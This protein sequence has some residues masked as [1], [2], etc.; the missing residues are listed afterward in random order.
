MQQLPKNGKLTVQLYENT[1]TGKK[2]EFYG[3]ILLRGS[4]SIEELADLLV[5]TGIGFTKEQILTISSR[6]ADAA[7]VCVA[8]GFSVKLDTCT[9]R[10]TI[11]G[12]FTGSSAP[13]DPSLHTINITISPS[14][15]A[16]EA[17]RKA[18]V[19]VTGLAPGSMVI[20]RV[21][22][23]KSGEENGRL[24]CGRSLKLFGTR[25]TIEGTAPKVGVWF[26]SADDETKRIAVE[27]GD[28]VDNNPSQL[29]VVIP[30]LENGEWYVE[31]TTQSS[32][33]KGILLK[34][35]RTTRFELPLIVL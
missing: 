32:N 26:I 5:D 31:V 28:I 16:R 24:T 20:N 27:P 15:R 11:N 18:V 23:V 33:T 14:S 22:D 6:L 29:T 30:E 3:K 9:L 2:D 12:V 21:F 13:F 25:L 1:L 10:A 7:L 19:T 4:V 34:E 17:I 35:P 8:D